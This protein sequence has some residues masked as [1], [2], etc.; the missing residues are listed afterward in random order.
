MK[1]MEY[2]TITA[3]A[4][5]NVFLVDGTN[6]TK[7]ILAKDAVLAALGLNSV[8]AHR[9]IFRGKD[10]GTSVTGA[11][12]IAIQSGTFD[13]LWLGDYWVINGVKWRIVD[14]DYW[15]NKGDTKFTN[16]HVVVMPDTSLTTAV[17]NDTN[18]T[19]NGYTGSKMYTNGLTSAKSII[20][21]AFS[22]FVLTHREYLINAVTSGYPSQ[23]AWQDSDIELPNEIM[24]FGSYISTPASNGTIDVKRFTVSN[25]QLA[26]FR[27]DPSMI[28]NGN[29]YW[30]RDVA[31]SS[32]F[33]CVDP[34][35]GAAINEASESFEVRP[36][37]AIG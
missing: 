11:Q 27:A 23:G 6:G 29:G 14:L 12:R 31:S 26:L 20:N 33:A 32:H 1:I 17:M 37:F 13:D 28:V 22:G 15:Y 24:I 19:D 8:N 30:L 25:T 7:K 36:V 21:N 3:L 4:D 34:T 16:H 18:T 35:G 10:L 2:P 9:L 5:D